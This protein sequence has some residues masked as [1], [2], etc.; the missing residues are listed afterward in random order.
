M[1]TGKEDA[2]ASTVTCPVTIFLSPRR[3]DLKE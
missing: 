2:S 1:S 3:A